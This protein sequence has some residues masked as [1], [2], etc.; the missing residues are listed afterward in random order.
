MNKT[1]DYVGLVGKNNFGTTMKI[2]AARNKA[3]IDVL[4]LDESGY[5]WKHN[6]YRNFIRGEIKNP[7][8]KSICGVG[9]LGDGQYKCW[10]NGKHTNEYVVW[11]N[12]IVRCYYEKEKSLHPTY[13]DFCTVCPEWHNFQ[14]FAEW[15]NQNKYKVEGRLHIDKDILNPNCNVYSPT[16]CL[17]VPQRVNMLFVKHIPN[18][19]GFPEGISK[20]LSGRFSTSYQGKSYGTYQTLSEACEKYIQVKKEK[21]IKIANEY[22]KIIPQKVYDALLNYKVEITLNVA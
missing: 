3:D 2:I 14:K 15:Y 1:K 20:T 11:K 12:M 8:D 19:Y 13:F 10:R 5:I 21:I 6:M 22:R 9:F 16:T 18:S 7:Y 17:L 4:F